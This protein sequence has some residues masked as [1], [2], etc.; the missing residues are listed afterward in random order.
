MYIQFDIKTLFKKSNPLF[1]IL[2]PL[3]VYVFCQ[4]PLN[5][6]LFSDFVDK[7]LLSNQNV[8]KFIEGTFN[9]KNESSILETASLMK[10]S[11]FLSPTFVPTVANVIPGE[12][13]IARPYELSL[14]IN[15]NGKNELENSES[16]VALIDPKQNIFCNFETVM[17]NK[18]NR[19][20]NCHT[21]DNMPCVPIE[22]NCVP[23]EIL[24]NTVSCPVLTKNGQDNVNGDIDKSESSSLEM[25][26]KKNVNTEVCTVPRSFKIDKK[27]LNTA[28]KNKINVINEQ[29]LDVSKLYKCKSINPNLNN[30]ILTPVSVGMVLP[31]VN[32]KHDTISSNKLCKIN[33]VQDLITLSHASD[34]AQKE[35]DVSH[36]EKICF[37]VEKDDFQHVN[38]NDDYT[39]VCSNTNLKKN[40]TNEI[41]EMDIKNSLEH[42]VIKVN[43]KV[44]Q[45]VKNSKQGNNYIKL[46]D[47]ITLNG[48]NNLKEGD[49]HVFRVTAKD[50]NSMNNA[51]I[52]DDNNC[53]ATNL[54]KSINGNSERYGHFD[55]YFHASDKLFNNS[56]STM[57]NRSINSSAP[58]EYASV[59]AKDAKMSRC[60]TDKNELSVN[61]ENL[62]VTGHESSEK[63]KDMSRVLSLKNIEK[64][65]NK[66]KTG[67]RKSKLSIQGVE[68][69]GGDF[70]DIK[71]NVKA[72]VNERLNIPQHK[73]YIKDQKQLMNELPESSLSGEKN[74]EMKKN[75]VLK[76][77]KRD[78]KQTKICNSNFNVHV[79]PVDDLYE[80]IEIETPNI[81]L[82]VVCKADEFCLC[83]DFGQLKY[84]DYDTSYE[85]I[86][87]WK[88]KDVTSDHDLIF[89]I[90]KVETMH[91]YNDEAIS[92]ELINESPEELMNKICWNEIKGV[93]NDKHAN[94]VYKN[95]NDHENKEIVQAFPVSVSSETGLS[96]NNLETS[97]INLPCDIL[98]VVNTP[99]IDSC[100]TTGNDVEKNIVVSEYNNSLD[101]ACLKSTVSI[102]KLFGI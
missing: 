47:G 99:D 17:E 16:F 58:S 39:L 49:P 21:N 12:M 91:N 93:D 43:K 72:E 69:P 50:M 37:M 60:M 33:D 94:D 45:N 46:F 85:H 73:T 67:L 24:E 3:Y 86:H 36:S 32:K 88:H 76:T 27:Q 90:Y 23:S 52:L 66:S 62:C 78:K 14:Q 41:T 70:E 55:L 102:V 54:G 34:K 81:N 74:K 10:E 18:K 68:K 65:S 101:N 80:A 71:K 87:F 84:Y 40:N 82:D 25:C 100:R 15:D 42:D 31:I 38:V 26:Q 11:V 20:N 83:G 57:H 48:D 95:Y 89:S 9:S 61:S 59:N 8:E 44:Y 63:I 96:K 75:K 19:L 1:I 29:V 30:N 51:E 6:F 79:K 56:K 92:V 22:T 13:E 5:M 4:M 28:T 64:E 53:E 77:Y 98:K 7:S 35:T 97:K 2:Y